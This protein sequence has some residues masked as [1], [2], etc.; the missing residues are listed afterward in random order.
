MLDR[1][2]THTYSLSLSYYFRG[3]LALQHLQGGKRS[4]GWGER[5]RNLSA[6]LVRCSPTAQSPSINATIYVQR[7]LIWSN[8]NRNYWCFKRQ[9]QSGCYN[10]LMQLNCQS[11]L[12]PH[13]A[14]A[15]CAIVYPLPVVLS[16]AH[17]LLVTTFF[18]IF[19]QYFTYL[20]SLIAHLQISFDKHAFIC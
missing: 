3:Q 7:G 15:G 9:Y 10:I 5:I 6:F 17:P 20:I 12:Q 11:V 8:S 4:G 1:S 16:I 14:T 2:H 19:I 18:Q 13:G